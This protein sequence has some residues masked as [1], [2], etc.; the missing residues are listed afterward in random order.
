MV[1]VSSVIRLFFGVDEG[2]RC[3]WGRK[4]VS[5][6]SFESDIKLFEG[7][8]EGVQEM[9]KSLHDEIFDQG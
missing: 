4:N 9:T 3:K 7:T 1:P 6:G 2:K 8:A 5:W